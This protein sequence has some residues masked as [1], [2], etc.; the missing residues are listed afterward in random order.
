VVFLRDRPPPNDTDR[1]G[2][3]ESQRDTTPARLQV[4]QSTAWLLAY[5][6]ASL[7]GRIIVLDNNINVVSPAAGIALVWLASSS[8]RR[9][10]VDA[11]LLGVSTMVVIG[12]TDGGTARTILSLV[13]VVQT[14]FAVW[15]LQRLVP[16]IWGTGGREPFN[17]LGQFGWLLFSIVAA[18]LAA[19]VVRTVI[20]IIVTPDDGWDMFVGRF[21]RQ[22]SAMATIGVLGLLIGGWIAQQRDR[23]EALVTRPSLADVLH[24]I[25]IELVSGL[26]F[27]IFWQEPEI[28]TTYI[29]TLTVV[30]AAIRF[31]PLI[32]ALHCVLIGA[33]T[34]VM[35]IQGYGPIANVD[36]L[37]LRAL[38]AQLFVVVI[39]VTGMT[40]ALVRQQIGATISSLEASEAVLAVRAEELDMVMAHLDDG[41]AIIEE[42][43]RVLHAN[44][45]L[46]TAFGSR[47]AEPLE[48][49]AEPGEETGQA[50]HPDGRPLEDADNPLY[51]ALAGEVI[52]SEEIHHTDEYGVFRVL[53]CSAFQVPHAEG[54]PKRV[55]IVLRDTTAASTYRESLVSFAGTV[56]HDLNNPLSIIDG[57]AEA[58]E[59]RL[60]ESDE[61][62]SVAAAPMVQHIRVG[63][64][65][66]RGF[67]SDLL[68]HAVARDQSLKCEP[69]SLTN[70]VKHIAATRDRPHGGGEIIAG[71]LIDVWAD[72]VLVRQV[73]DNLVGNSFKYVA[74]GTVPRVLI[75]A[76][77][78][79]NG[80]A[81]IQVRDNGIG[82]SLDQRDRIFEDFH[83]ATVDN[84]QGTGLGLA[85]CRR[86]VQRHGGR[87]SVTDNPDGVG[88]CFEF[89]LPTSPDAFTAA[90]T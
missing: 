62:D 75:E 38:L 41:V 36:D 68:A 37:E 49:I 9:L 79:E 73:L 43:G 88:S 28:P 64:D 52:E 89:T 59:E 27:L 48:R 11:V 82:V 81:R 76:E 18:T 29:L 22:A 40:I 51:R 3:A 58:L 20:G 77:P 46:L 63:V 71:E 10:P 19:M 15:L 42:G 7:L 80:M 74:E 14:L 6:L 65:Q 5:V 54:A 30:W 23:G 86:I 55:M 1:V 70:L 45:A 34:V 90:N 39:M 4:L 44:Q 33:V 66:M 67:I 24:A 84:Y 83:R 78:V 60:T 61:P 53:E 12:L 35:T 25:G 16:G 26:L 2:W 21:G 32:T 56:A 85:I 57:W 13:V 50:Y 31:G 8:R 17:R 87:I 47:E 69:V 72:R